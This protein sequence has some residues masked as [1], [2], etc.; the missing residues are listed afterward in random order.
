MQEV[1]KAKEATEQV[2]SFF[3]DLKPQKRLDR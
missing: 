2:A 3:Q 1:T